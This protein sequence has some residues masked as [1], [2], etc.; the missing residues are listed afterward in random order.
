MTGF[1]TLLLLPV[2]AGLVAGRLLGGRLSELAVPR[3]GATWLLWVAAA[4]QIA[5]ATTGLPLM[6]S[7]F[8][9]V[10]GW[11][12]INLV[13]ATTALRLGLFLGLGGLVANGTSIGLNG[14]M[15]YVPDAAEAVGLG[16]GVVT[17]KNEPVDAST[18]L[19]WLGD[20]MPIPPLGAV[21]SIGDILLGLGIAVVVAVLM[22]PGRKAVA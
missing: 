6:A 7:V 11:F 4:V 10:L 9:L 14:R 18:V 2:L 5:Q 19:G 20:T 8:V 21:V 13:R 15:P 22:R 16:S 1:M 17:T 12:V 3:L